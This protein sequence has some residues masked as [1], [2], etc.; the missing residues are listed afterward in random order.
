MKYS[1]IPGT[2]EKVSVIGL[3]TW[4]LGGENWGGAKEDESL[5]AVRK[6]IDLGMNFIDLAPFYGDGLAEAVVGKAIR[7]QRGKVFLA[8]KCGIIRQNN[9][10]MTCLT[11]ESIARE[12]DLSRQRLGVD[13]ID[14][15][16]CHWPDDDTPV[17]K[18]MEALLYWQK[19]GAIRHI[20][21]SNF[22]LSLLKRAIA[23]APVKTLQIQY[24]LIERSVEAEL[25][26]FCLA[27]NIGVIAYG[28]MA[29]G[30]LTGKYDK[31]PQFHK[32]DAR[33]M[34]YKFYDDKKFNEGRRIV[35]E[36]KKAGRPLNQVA[37][38]WVCRQKGVMSVL[39]GCRTPA[40][41]VDNGA[42]ADWDMEWTLNS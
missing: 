11:P 8:T 1:F 5:G 17:E 25:L 34:F 24:S 42:T 38:N 15:Y 19:K 4:V 16:Q 12:L 23:A 20:G 27:N 6:A 14:L 21:V 10:V 3:G 37:L 18:T 31:K 22:E 33:H 7:G 30:F 32:S 41:V 29:G 28:A 40:Q 13:T 9:R 35:E 2:E 36:M 26:P 39:A